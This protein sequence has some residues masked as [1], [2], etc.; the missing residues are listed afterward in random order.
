[1]PDRLPL[2]TLSTTRASVLLLEARLPH[3][4]VNRVRFRSSGELRAGEDAV[5]Y[6]VH[7]AEHG[8]PAKSVRVAVLEA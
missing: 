7:L 5:R 3:I 8:I 2:S 4:G 6:L 1:M